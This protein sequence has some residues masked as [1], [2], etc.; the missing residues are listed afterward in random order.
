MLEHHILVVSR[1]VTM[2]RC[3]ATVFLVIGIFSNLNAIELKL[4]LITGAPEPSKYYYIDVPETLGFTCEV[5]EYDGG[6]SGNFTTIRHIDSL[7][8]LQ[9]NKLFSICEVR[10]TSCFELLDFPTPTIVRWKFYIPKELPGLHNLTC[11]VAINENISDV[12]NP[13]LYLEQTVSF[14]VLKLPTHLSI[15]PLFDDGPLQDNVVYTY[16]CESHGGWPSTVQLQ[17]R[18][19]DTILLT[20]I[21][22]KS[23][24]MK[25]RLTIQHEGAFWE[26]QDVAHQHR[27]KNIE[28]L[29]PIPKLIYIHR[30]SKPAEEIRLQNYFPLKT[31][32]SC[33]DYVSWK[34]NASFNWYGIP[35]G[36]LNIAKSDKYVIE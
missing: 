16:T 33:S 29:G 21:G 19:N 9:N 8:I 4:N 22:Q 12:G 26:C 35:I 13:S 30:N 6:I 18:H 17:L 25:L 2:F 24:H 32:I 15:S 7:S 20:S 31:V 14:E 3:L 1:I 36:S 5:Y 28:R 11:L 34:G 23:T 27:F 10:N